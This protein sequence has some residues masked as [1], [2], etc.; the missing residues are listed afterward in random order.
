MSAPAIVAAR[1]SNARSDASEAAI[2]PPPSALQPPASAGALG[3]GSEVDSEVASGRV[4]EQA[5]ATEAR[6]AARNPDDFR[7]AF[8]STG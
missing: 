3:P 5:I 8:T 6:T 7:F 4:A 1:R 2:D